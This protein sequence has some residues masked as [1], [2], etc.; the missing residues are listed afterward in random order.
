[1]GSSM[2]RIKLKIML[3]RIKGFWEEYRRNRIG[4]VG[5]A[6]ILFFIITAF[7]APIISPHNPTDKGL[8]VPLALPLWMKIFPK[9]QDLPST[10]ISEVDFTIAES[11]DFIDVE[12]TNYDPEICGLLETTTIRD[13]KVKYNG[14]PTDPLEIKLIWNF[15]YPYQSPPIIRQ[16]FRWR[17]V[18]IRD[19]GYNI[20]LS[21]VR[22]GNEP[23]EYSLWDSNFKKGT[24][25]RSLKYKEDYI[26]GDWPRLVKIST[27]YVESLS[28]IAPQV[29]LKEGITSKSVLKEMFPEKG[30]YGLIMYVRLNPKS[31]NASCEIDIIDPKYVLLGSAHGILGTNHEGADILSRLIYG[32]KVSLSI[33]LIV[34]VISVVIGTFIGG[35]SG[36]VGGFVDEVNM[37]LVDL[38]LCL[39]IF[40]LLLA[41]V[42]MFGRDLYLIMFLLALLSWMGLSRTVRS[43][44]LSLREMAF[45]ESAIASGATK[46]Y[47]LV[48]HIIPN[49]TPLVFTSMMLSIPGA[50]LSESSLS[51]LGFGDPKV[52]SWG[53]IINNAMNF[54][55]FPRG[56][57]WWI[58]SP[59]VAIMLLS[60]GFVF[61]S[62]ALDQIINP[63]LRQRK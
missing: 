25:E 24:P 7:L 6:I 63:R 62:H 48:K 39:P 18:D 30:E 51:F 20:E 11:N 52:M 31:T 60:A 9:N 58:F 14:G 17:V 1:M 49:I 42:L 22:W 29:G 16:S 61:V 34:A 4:I 35:V 53:R 33:G 57:W 23:A 44:V 2:R 56:A 45:V 36:Y 21:L 3:S 15:N 47:I 12:F 40:P 10:Q 41:L 46:G 55:A 43:Q 27:D 5:L 54:G 38:L 19:I 32:V 28:R 26:Y 37:R 59:A 50:I 13:W 8:A